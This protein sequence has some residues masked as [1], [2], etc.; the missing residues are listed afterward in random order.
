MGL[1]MSPVPRIAR[2]GDKADAMQRQLTL[3]TPDQEK[4]TLIFSRSC[5]RL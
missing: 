2:R 5:N 1:R 3:E 4:Q